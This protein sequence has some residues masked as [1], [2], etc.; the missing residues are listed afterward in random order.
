VGHAEQVPG[1][2]TLN[3]GLFATVASVSCP[4]AGH[5]VAGGYFTGK[6]LGT[7]AFVDSQP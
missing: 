2:A 6:N 1:T 4:S 3:K 5:C 7:Q